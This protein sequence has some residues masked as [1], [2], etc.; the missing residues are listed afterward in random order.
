MSVVKIKV[1]SMIGRMSELDNTTSVL[2]E[3]CAFH[4]DNTLSFYSDTS[5]FSPLT[6]ENPYSEALRQLTDTLKSIDKKIDILSVR[7][8]KKIAGSMKDWDKY[9]KNTAE[10]FSSLIRERDESRQKISDY[11]REIEKTKHFIGLDLNLDELR[12]CRFIKLRFGS[13]PKESY[14]KLNEYK[15]NPYVV[16]FT[17]T[18]DPEK[19]W[20]MYCAPIEMVSEVDRIFSSLYFE[21]THLNELVGTPES[22]I[23]SLQK[24]QDEEKARV[25]QISARIEEIWAN[26]KQ[27]IQNIYS[28]LSEKFICFGIRRYAARYGDNFILTGWIPADKENSIKARLD[29]LDSVK[30]TLENAG[31]PDILPHSPPVKLKNKKFFRPFEYFVEIYGLP[32]YDE[33]DPTWM[34]AITYIFL[35]GV[36]F[37]DL[38]QGICISLIGWLMYKKHKMQLGR[39]LVPCGIASAFFGALFGSVF[40]FEHAL[41]PMYKGLFGLSQKPISVMEPATTNTIIYSAVGLGIF[42]VIIAMLMNIY[43]SIKRKHYTNAFFG[44]NGV[45]GLVFYGSLVFGL[46][47]QIALGLNIFSKTYVICL[48]VIPLILMFFREILGGLAE[49]SPN[50]KPESWGDYIMQNIFEVFEFLLSYLTNTISFIRVGAFVL[51]H[52][53]MMMVVFMLAEMCPGIGYV[54]IVLIGNAFVMALEGLLVGIQS[55]RLEFYEM[56]SRFFDG[57]GRPFTP[58]IVGQES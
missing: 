26:E 32:A 52:A 54:I 37:A 33:V 43:S 30:Y 36:M 39:A 10:T 50:W 5:G 45:A 58:V 9:T 6:E 53:G 2:G 47:G 42:L 15:E 57:D 46:V 49:G 34:V 12:E 35:F 55:L 28:W 19:Y 14:E 23:D 13:I 56:F 11:G 38:G 25:T 27:N 3:S 29:Q 48:I 18:S 4:P 40:G 51:V 16:F 20:G 24:K 17:S 31:K 21:R 7:A 44:P 1:L 8:V 22:V 41:D